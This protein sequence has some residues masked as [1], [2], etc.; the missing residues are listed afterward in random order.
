LAEKNPLEKK[1]KQRRLGKGKKGKSPTKQERKKKVEERSTDELERE[2][3]KVEN[4]GGRV[5]G[6]LGG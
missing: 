3:P 5:K 2:R 4:W 1:E 6:T